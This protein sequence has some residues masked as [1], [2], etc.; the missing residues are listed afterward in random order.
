MKN[1]RKILALVLALATLLSL[2]ACG[3]QPETPSEP[4]T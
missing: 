3:T 2:A 1:V 4:S